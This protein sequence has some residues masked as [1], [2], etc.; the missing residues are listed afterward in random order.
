MLDVVVL[1]LVRLH[2]FH[3]CGARLN[4]LPNSLKSL[5]ET[6]YGGEMDIQFM[7]NSSGGYFCMPT[8]HSLKICDVRCIVLCDKTAQFRVYSGLPKSQLFET[9]FRSFVCI[10]KVSKFKFG[11]KNK[12]VAFLFLFSVDGETQYRTGSDCIYNHRII[13]Q[14]MYNDDMFVSPDFN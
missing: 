12:S 3:G 8:A 5:L 6:V 11:S 4:V 2:V 1:R 7:G 13:L 10:E 9:F 14:N